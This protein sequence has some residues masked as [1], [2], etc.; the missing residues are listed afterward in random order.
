[1]FD[2][3]FRRESAAGRSSKAQP[4]FDEEDPQRPGT[5]RN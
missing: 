4:K 5:G 2:E 1:M 3:L